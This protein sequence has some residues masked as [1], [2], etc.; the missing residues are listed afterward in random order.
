MRNILTIILFACSTS[1]CYGQIKDSVLH[2]DLVNEALSDQIEY[3]LESSDYKKRNVLLMYAPLI[4]S[5]DNAQGY[6]KKNFI[7]NTEIQYLTQKQIK[8]HSKKGVSFLKIYP[9]RLNND[10]SISILIE[11][12]TIKR[13]EQ[14]LVGSSTYYFKYDCSKN[15]YALIEKKQNMI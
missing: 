11:M 15:K 14:I 5:D 2:Y 12:V 13:K 7:D 8:K 10:N 1:I 4:Y 9:L 6:Q 3:E